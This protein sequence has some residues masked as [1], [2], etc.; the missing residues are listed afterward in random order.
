MK[1]ISVNVFEFFSKV[2]TFKEA[3][4]TLDGLYIKRKKNDLKTSVCY[5]VSQIY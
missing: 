3:L 4:G 1:F 2:T 5:Q